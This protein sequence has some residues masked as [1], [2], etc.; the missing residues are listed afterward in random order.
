[1][2]EV[3]V[4]GCRKARIAMLS[5]IGTHLPVLAQDGLGCQGPQRPWSTTISQL[6]AHPRQSQLKGR[7][8]AAQP[9]AAQYFVY[10]KEEG[11]TG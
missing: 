3:S 5:T 11:P 8:R 1:M 7:K 9:E 10:T 6:I 2:S 4:E